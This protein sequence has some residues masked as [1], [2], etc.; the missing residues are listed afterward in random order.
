MVKI[1]KVNP[2]VDVASFVGVTEVVAEAEVGITEIGHT[3]C[4]PRPFR[5]K[6]VGRARTIDRERT[7]KRKK[8]GP[9]VSGNSCLLFTFRQSKLKRKRLKNIESKY[10]QILR[11]LAFYRQNTA[12]P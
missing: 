5:A 10:K 12:K 9:Q 4:L 8:V 1:S 6:K 2:R 3:L 11:S 7:K